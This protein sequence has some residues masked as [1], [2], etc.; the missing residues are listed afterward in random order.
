[1]AKDTDIDIPNV[2]DDENKKLALN[3]INRCLKGL[4][5][6]PEVLKTAKFELNR[7][8]SEAIQ[9]KENRKLNNAD[10]RFNYKMLDEL[11]SEESKKK[12]KDLFNKSINNLK[13]I[14]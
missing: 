5:F 13:F 7:Q 4:P 9:E 14:E 11:G 10:R 6:N 2:N 8:K 3:I 1:M 12:V